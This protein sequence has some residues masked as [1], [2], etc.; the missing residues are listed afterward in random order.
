MASSKTNCSCTRFYTLSES[1]CVFGL[2]A[3]LFVACYLLTKDIEIHRIRHEKQ[4]HKK[5][6][7]KGKSFKTE[8]CSLSETSCGVQLMLMNHDL[9]PLYVNHWMSTLHLQAPFCLLCEGF[10]FVGE[11]SHYNSTRDILLAMSPALADDKLRKILASH[12][13]SREAVLEMLSCCW[14]FRNPAPLEM[15]ETPTGAEFL[16]QQESDSL[17]HHLQ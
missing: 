10:R 14:W 2:F 4:W 12:E 13:Q 8:S 16:N 3:L 1:L 11:A 15:Y 7:D 9:K 5:F 17:N 6:W